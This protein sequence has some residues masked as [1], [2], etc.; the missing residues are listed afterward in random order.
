[1]TETNN[2]NNAWFRQ[3]LFLGILILMGAVM[4]KQLTFFVGSFLGAVTF[5]IVFRKTVFRMV[6][7]HRWPAWL[8]SLV[9]VLA[10]CAVLIGLG[11]LVFVLFAGEVRNVDMSQIPVIVHEALPKLN[12]LLGFEIIPADVVKARICLES[13]RCYSEYHIQLCGEH[14]YDRHNPLLYARPRA[15]NGGRRQ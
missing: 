8:A 4:L 9:I 3:M 7:R 11:Y 12:E 10:I 14:I 6:E 2:K 13:R 1:M 5:Y 15:K